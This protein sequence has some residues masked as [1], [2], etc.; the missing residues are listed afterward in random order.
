MIAERAEAAMGAL[1]AAPITE[2]ARVVLAALAGD[3]IH[4]DV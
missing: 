4:R 1:A 3:A 2:E